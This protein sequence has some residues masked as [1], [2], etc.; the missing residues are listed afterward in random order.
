MMHPFIHRHWPK[1]IGAIV[2]GL[3]LVYL[4]TRFPLREPLE[5]ALNWS[6]GLGPMSYLVFVVL[7]VVC[8]V[9]LIPGTPL[10]LASGFIFGLG[11][12]DP[13]LAG[14]HAEWIHQRVP[15]WPNAGP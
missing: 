6:R 13:H 2:C 12:G 7:Y 15:A 3:L 8:T 11:A 5:A 4:L 9:C 1:L 14:R 10:T